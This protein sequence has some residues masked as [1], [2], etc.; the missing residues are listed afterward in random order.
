MGTAGSE[1][2]SLT[3][4]E[5]GGEEGCSDGGSREQGN[6]T[7]DESVPS[8]QATV[9]KDGDLTIEKSS[10]CHHLG[11]TDV[12]CLQPA[13]AASEQYQEVQPVI[14]SGRQWAVNEWLMDTRGHIQC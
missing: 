1:V 3:A 10:H 13:H 8:A 2:G 9:V 6:E 7:E 4:E 5:A 11:M 14:M 12:S